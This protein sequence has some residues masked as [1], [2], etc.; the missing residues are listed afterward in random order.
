[1]SEKTDVQFEDKLL[2]LVEDNADD[3]LLMIR[4]LRKASVVNP[5]QTLE[6]G[7]M[8]IDYL[9]GEGEYGD[10]IKHPLPVLILLDL[11]LPIVS[12]FEVLEWL[13]KQDV[14]RRIPVVI[15]TS[16]NVTEDINKAYDLGVN[17][18]L[19]KPVRFEDLLKI[20]KNL[21]VYWM[22]LNQQPVLGGY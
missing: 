9:Q 6:N 15:L 7:Q 5:I 14:L 18:Y 4:A 3:S 11:K 12:G 1:M 13:R 17:S 20:S 19:V 10:R 22:A 16:S 8:A 2:L 21:G